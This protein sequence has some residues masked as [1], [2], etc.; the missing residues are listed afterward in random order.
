MKKFLAAPFPIQVC[1]IIIGVSL[2]R[3]FDFETNRFR[4]LALVLVYLF[5]FGLSLFF[6]FRG[7]K[8]EKKE[9]GV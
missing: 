5:A 6:V 4:N 9:G 3:E 1:L 7:K 2:F 8:E